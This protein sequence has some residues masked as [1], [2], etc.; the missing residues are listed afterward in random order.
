MLKCYIFDIV[1][2]EGEIVETNQ[3]EESKTR[4]TNRGRN[5]KKEREGK[6]TAKREKQHKTT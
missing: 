3:F 1:F 6:I 2:K 5:S 4:K